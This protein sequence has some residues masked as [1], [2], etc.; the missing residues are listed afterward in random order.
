MQ[1]FSNPP[2]QAALLKNISVSISPQES[3]SIMHKQ[4]H[5]L[6]PVHKEQYL[7]LWWLKTNKSKADSTQN[8]NAARK[9]D[10]CASCFGMRVQL[11]AGLGL[12]R[13]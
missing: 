2:R 4:K 12:G 13:Q 10:V 3:L 1:F 9:S 6:L 8:I 7:Y 5:L 11:P